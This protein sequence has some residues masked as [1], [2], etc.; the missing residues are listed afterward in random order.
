MGAIAL[1]L[2]QRLQAS[3]TRFKKYVFEVDK[4]RK[5]SQESPLF[6][7]MVK[8]GETPFLGL[9]TGA[10]R[11]TY[12]GVKLGLGLTATALS[13][14]LVPLARGVEMLARKILKKPGQTI[15]PLL[16]IKSGKNFSV[17]GLF[18]LLFGLF[19]MI[20][21]GSSVLRLY[22]YAFSSL[23]CDK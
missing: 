13:L 23:K 20:T 17:E 18:H 21:L 14:T 3:G 15:Y 12:G 7:D 16:C 10:A 2:G 11:T 9:F 6:Y 22:Y 5:G 8:W 1:S 4:T 19:E